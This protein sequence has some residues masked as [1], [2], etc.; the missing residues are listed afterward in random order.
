MSDDISLYL[1]GLTVSSVT[2]LGILVHSNP[3]VS[4]ISPH[5][6]LQA[7]K[8]KT[9]KWIYSRKNPHSSR[10]LFY[11]VYSFSTT[12]WPVETRHKN[13]S[14]QEFLFLVGMKEYI[15][16]RENLFYLSFDLIPLLELSGD[17]KSRLHSSVKWIITP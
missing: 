9:D 4:F 5:C 7:C 2:Q 3:F 1:L 10:S 8:A 13:K 12:T 6:I 16:L 11:E 17:R 15:S 14:L